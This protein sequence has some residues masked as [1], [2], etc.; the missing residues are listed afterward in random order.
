M[1]G[2]KV[3]LFIMLVLSLSS[4]TTYQVDAATYK[5]TDDK[6]QINHSQMPPGGIAFST[7]RAPSES[8]SVLA[9]TALLKNTQGMSLIQQH[10]CQEATHLF[11][12]LKQAHDK[13]EQEK[14]NDDM[15]KAKEDMRKYCQ[16]S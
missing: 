9:E 3:F 6:G 5:W 14:M 15:L 8:Q 7:L 12:A 4:C 11:N 2:N 10:N 1:I 13:N 16:T